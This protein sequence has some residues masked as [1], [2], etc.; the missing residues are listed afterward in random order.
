MA[1]CCARNS[2]TARSV[3]CAAKASKFKDLH[4]KTLAKVGEIH[5]R[6]IKNRI[7]TFLTFCASSS[8]I[9]IALAYRDFARPYLV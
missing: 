8:V 5:R 1:R 4:G 7:G 9:R 2:N 6:T 3:P